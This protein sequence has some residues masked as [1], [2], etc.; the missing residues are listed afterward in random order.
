MS[1]QNFCPECHRYHAPGHCQPTEAPPLWRHPFAPIASRAASGALEDKAAETFAGYNADRQAAGLEMREH[2]AGV[3]RS[4]ISE[5]GRI[6]SATEVARA[7][8]PDITVEPPISK[9]T[10]QW[11]LAHI[12]EV[13]ALRKHG[14]ALRR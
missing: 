6:P 10:I 9:R 12:P 14:G 7:L 3:V 4:Y 1:L 13:Q 2:I 8:I 11:H 5:H